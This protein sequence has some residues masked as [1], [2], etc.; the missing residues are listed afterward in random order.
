MTAR[1]RP[2]T[3]LPQGK[4]VQTLRSPLNWSPSPLGGKWGTRETHKERREGMLAVERVRRELR[5][6]IHDETTCK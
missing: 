6:A 2:A 1:P 3:T 4:G 5:V